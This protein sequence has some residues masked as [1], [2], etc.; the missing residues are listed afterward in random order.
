MFFIF[1]KVFSELLILCCDSQDQ[2]IT[3]KTTF[4]FTNTNSISH[5]QVASLDV[6]LE[7]SKTISLESNHSIRRNTCHKLIV[8]R[9]FCELNFMKRNS[10][11]EP[12]EAIIGKGTSISE[13]TQ[14]ELEKIS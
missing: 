8:S 4:K 3:R 12:F 13:T 14:K 11:D 10:S 5:G 9:R 1:S 7:C 2:N 6:S